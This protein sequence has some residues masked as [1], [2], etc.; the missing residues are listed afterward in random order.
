MAE[1]KSDETPATN[2]PAPNAVPASPPAPSTPANRPSAAQPRTK[3]PAAAKTPTTRYYQVA[4][5]AVGGW[6]QGAIITSDD[7]AQ[8]GIDID[9]LLK[10][11]A[12]AET[13]APEADAPAAD[14]GE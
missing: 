11:G 14:D 9:R 8:P 10:L 1:H 3:A 2:T 6:E 12:I 4:H 13:A 7:L 5:G